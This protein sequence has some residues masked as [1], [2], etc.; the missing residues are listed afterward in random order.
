MRWC[1]SRPV[2]ESRE[3]YKLFPTVKRRLDLQPITYHSA[4]GFLD[5]LK[6]LM[7]KLKVGRHPCIA[8]NFSNASRRQ[9]IGVHSLVSES[10]WMIHFLTRKRRNDGSAPSQPFV[11][12]FASC[13]LYRI[14]G[15]WTWFRASKGKRSMSSIPVVLLNMVIGRILT[16]TM[17]WK[18][19]TVSL[20]SVWHQLEDTIQPKS[21]L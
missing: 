7:A 5:I 14:C 18:K 19:M 16:P 11:G 1:E 12:H 17:W 3:F 8:D 4:V 21:P 9:M 13:S 2:I 10:P 20:A 6:T 15:N